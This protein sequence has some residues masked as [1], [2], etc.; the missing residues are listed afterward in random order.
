MK[1]GETS[2]KNAFWIGII[3][4]LFTLPLFGHTQ[5]YISYDDNCR[6]IYKDIIDLKL[7]SAKEKLEVFS[8]ANPYNLA[9]LHLENYL[10]FFELFINEDID[11]FK[12]LEK[13][14]QIRLDLIEKHIS[15]EDPYKK[16]VQAEIKLQ[17]AVT[18]SKF[19][20]LFK[21]AREVLSAYNLLKEN[22]K[23]HP[24]FIYNKKS[25][26]IIHSLIETI[27]IPGLFKKFFGIK[28][29]IKLGIEEIKSVLEYSYN[30]DF[31]FNEEADAIYTF[32]LF[33]QNNQKEKA[34]T[35][36]NSS[37]LNPE[38]SLLATF[39]YAKIAQ[40]SGRNTEAI[41]ILEYKAVGSQYAAFYY[42]DLLMGISQL[43]N[44]DPHCEEHIQFFIDN[45]K[46]QHFIKEAHQ[47]M[48]WAKI[49]FGED[50]AGYKYYMS[51]LNN[52]GT[53]LVDDDKQ[54]QKEHEQKTIPNPTLLKAR[55]LYDGGYYEKAH[56]LLTIKAHNFIVNGIYNLE[57]NYRLG[58]TAQALKNYPEAIKYLSNTINN[59]IDREE[60][61]A[62]NAALQ[63]ARIYE[64]Q[65]NLE[66]AKKYYQLCLTINP[67]EYKNSLH[68]KAKTGLERIKS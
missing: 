60:Y 8:E 64:N 36:L 30:N 68:Q 59:G 24:S 18:R 52:H 6:T 50:I 47:K 29:S 12:I 63:I 28:G 62:C 3:T 51:E 9:R 14:K 40:R 26:S 27:T 22:T 5:Y 15:D 33:Y 17:W 42:L 25:L 20:Q 67:N 19:D 44:L 38:E 23:D 48:A 56:R 37:R 11:R 7:E 45:F 57:F 55:M 43:R 13:R 1:P 35:F 21:A 2:F 65:K 34:W 61:Y 10:D 49:I 31:I 46:G 66:K 39:L 32:I 4:I 54:A 41:K 16:F 58:R 53:T